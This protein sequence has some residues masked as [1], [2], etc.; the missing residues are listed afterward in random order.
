MLKK[1]IPL[2]VFVL[3][4]ACGPTFQVKPRQEVAFSQMNHKIS[5]NIIEMQAKLLSE[6]QIIETFDA[7]LLLAGIIPIQVTITNQTQQS[8][9]F[10]EKDFSVIDSQGQSI[11]NLNAKDALE[12]LFDYYKIRAYNPYS[13]EKMQ[14]NF[15]THSL[16]LALMPNESRSGLLYFK[17]EKANSTK[18]LKLKLTRK[19]IFIES[20]IL[21]LSD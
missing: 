18:G 12:R 7:N 5:N 2:I 10:M 11:T 14:A 13:Y 1:F 17:P 16:S 3:F 9:V 21:K 19:K 6:D 15:L 8:I 20:L 4:C